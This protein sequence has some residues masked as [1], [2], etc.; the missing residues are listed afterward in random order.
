MATKTVEIARYGD[1][2]VEKKYGMSYDE[3]AE[4]HLFA[5]Y[6]VVIGDACKDWPAREKF[7]PE[8]FKKNYGS[9]EVKV[10]GNVYSLG[11]FIDL[12]MVSTEENPAPYPC[13]LQVDRDY[14]ELIPDVSP[15]FMYAMPDWTHH[16]LLPERFLGA[17]DTL[18]IFFGSQGG[19]FPY[20]HYDYMCLHAYITQLFGQKEFM[21]IPPDQT[22]YVYPDPERPWVS[23][24]DNQRN[25]DLERFPLFAKA[26][27]VSFVV[28][29]GETL[30]IPCGWWHTAHSLTPTISV[31]LDCLNASNWKPFMNEVETMMDR[32]KTVKAKVAKAYLSGLGTVLTSS[33]KLNLRF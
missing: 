26:T 1:I 32:G 31:A 17:A 24:I 7:T 9:R 6:P 20:L 23:L 11:E 10:S 25:P 5:N 22:S 28:G 15:R 27:P 12:M 14:P 29:P 33:E 2:V 4:K 18:E 19:Q 16:K 30:F 3:F 21:V 8:F 13:K